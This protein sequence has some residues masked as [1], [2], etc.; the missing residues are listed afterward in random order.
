ME[1]D[2]D[3]LIFI[4]RDR[5]KI[6]IELAFTVTNFVALGSRERMLCLYGCCT[7]Q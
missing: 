3:L 1:K 2:K 5:E 6:G 4:K 7:C